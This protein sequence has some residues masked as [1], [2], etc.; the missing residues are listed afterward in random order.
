MAP[1]LGDDAELLE[2]AAWLHDIGY[3]PELADT[4]FHPLDGARYLRDVHAADPT[5][6]RLVANHSCAVIEAGERGLDR[7]LLAEFPAADSEPQR[8]PRLLR[9]DHDPHR[10][11]GVRDDRLSEIRQRYGPSNVV[12]RFTHKAE[13]DLVASVARITCRLNRS[14]CPSS[15]VVTA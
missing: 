10:W 12:T 9:H 1:I 4:G 14:P 15:G 5:L 8:C 6:C 13:P 2:A 11:L 3:S 7:E